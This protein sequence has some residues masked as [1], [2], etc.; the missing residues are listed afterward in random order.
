MLFFRTI[1]LTVVFTLLSANVWAEERPAPD[2]RIV[3]DISGS[4]KETD[5]ENLRRPALNLLTELLPEG[6]RAGVWTFG[7]YVNMLVPLGTVDEAW[8]Q[9][10]R[11][12]SGD[13]SSVGLNTNLVD[14]L[15][16]A[17]YEATQN[18]QFDQ[19]VIL[20]TDGRIDMDTS[21]GDPDTAANTAAR[22]RLISA[23]LPE[24]MSKNVRIHT[25][26]L[27]DAADVSMLGQ[28]A[29]ETD[30]LAL[31]AHTNDELMPAFLKAFDRAVPS[32]Q[33]PLVGNTFNIDPSVNEFT[34]LIFRAASSKPTELVSPSGLRISQNSAATSA[35]VRWHHDL[36]F[37]LIT[38]KSPEDGEWAADADV[39]PDSRVQILSDL[40][41]K[42][43]GLPGSLFSGVPV[44]LE[45][46]LENEGETVDEET[47][48]QLTDVSLQVTAPDGRTGSKL[49]S[50][51]ESLPV[52]GIF[53]ETLSRLNQPGEYRLE[54]N[55]QGR[56][57]ER[58]QVLTATLA[59][60][61]RVEVEPDVN[62]QILNV[63][64][65][66]QSDLVDTS[67]SRVISRIS[68]PDGSSMINA[69]EYSGENDAWELALMADKGPGNYEIMLNIRGVSA[70]GKTFKSK[71]ESI[72][73]TFPLVS[74]SAPER[75]ALASMMP[76]QPQV[77]GTASSED[78]PAENEGGAAESAASPDN[79]SKQ[80]QPQSE[81][82]PSQ[83]VSTPAPEEVVPDLA[84]RYSEQVATE[85]VETEEESG[86]AW[87]IYVLLGVANLALLGGLAWWWLMRRKGKAES[88][89]DVAARESLDLET[90]QLDDADL[91]SAD[92]DNFDGAEE[93]EIPAAEEE[94]RVTASM[95]GDTDMGSPE[96][97]A[98]A[99]ESADDDDDWGEFD[100][101]DD[102]KE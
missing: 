90:G 76:E 11:A 21:G 58:K 94:S 37:D 44:Q 85:E 72:P 70:S 4:M 74:E 96:P 10:A 43:T 52:D 47:I 84:A 46:S 6:A 39:A 25:L 12:A 63:R 57:F 2:V 36:N 82:V 55:A 48:L 78:D 35:D 80:E 83:D 27:S 67:L 8:R 3:I 32:E 99:A 68:S 56:T 97:A 98:D 100:L 91:D 64:V 24:Y 14:A 7:R 38:V 31:K 18:S 19:T 5:P 88:P 1:C 23:V 51:P 60:P 22:E 34:A 86:V 30:G 93:E 89:E 101:P 13:I 54:I 69:M 33:V 9:K 66:P 65:Y 49:L 73:V 17:L 102:K 41:L 53:R 15:D 40:K 71:P 42:V 20:L 45:M 61:M 77:A 62:Q 75:A 79:Q 26:A 59:E 95:G 29:M 92:F 81:E 50:D 87:W 16:R 28:L